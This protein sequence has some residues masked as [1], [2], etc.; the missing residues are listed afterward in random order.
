MLRVA[1]QAGDGLGCV[2]DGSGRGAVA[3]SRTPLRVLVPGRWHER[4]DVPVSGKVPFLCGGRLRRA[5]GSP[6]SSG[7]AS[8]ERLRILLRWRCSD[9]GG[10][11]GWAFGAGA[12]GA[13]LEVVGVGVCGLRVAGVFDDGRE[14]VVA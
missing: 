6:G 12:E 3:E 2:R 7:D 4:Y 11:G 14:L 13:G 1:L 5:S 8:D 10:F 9:V